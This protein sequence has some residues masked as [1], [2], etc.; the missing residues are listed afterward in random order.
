MSATLAHY[1]LGIGSMFLFVFAG[2][3]K[4]SENG[5]LAMFFFCEQG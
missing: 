2:L 1:Q 5:F 3:A 4:Y